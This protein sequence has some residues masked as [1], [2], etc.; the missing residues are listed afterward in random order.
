MT[1]CYLEKGLLCPRKTYLQKTQNY[2]IKSISCLLTIGPNALLGYR[3][4]QSPDYE[5]DNRGAY[6]WR[7]SVIGAQSEP[8]TSKTRNLYYIQ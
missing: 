7:W 1:I 4:L 3:H 2:Q 6:F 5:S 8:S